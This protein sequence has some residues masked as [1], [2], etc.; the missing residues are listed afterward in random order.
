MT[1]QLLPVIRDWSAWSAVFTDADLW[2][3]AIARLWADE[4]SLAARTGIGCVETVTAGFPGTCAVFIVNE[5]AVIK[6][7]P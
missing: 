4:P 2:R 1:I 6:L 5:T 7:F 3:P